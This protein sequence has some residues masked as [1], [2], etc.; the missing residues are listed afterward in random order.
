MQSKLIR[1]VL[2]AVIAPIAFGGASAQN[3]STNHVVTQADL[4]Q[5]LAKLSNWGRWGNDDQRGTLNL[6]TKV[7][8]IQAAA[9][10]KDGVTVSLSRDLDSEKAIDNTDPFEDV[11]MRDGSSDGSVIDRMSIAFQGEAHTHIDSVAHKLVD[12]K[13]Y[14]GYEAKDYV[15]MQKGITKDS[16]IN[17]KTGI[18][19]RGI[20]M[21]IPMLKGVPYLDPTTP[22]YVEDLEAWEK[23]A[24]VKVAPGD[25]IFIRTGRWVRRAKLGAWD[26]RQEQAGLDASVIP[27][28]KA[29]GVAL[30]GSESALSVRPTPATTQIKDP[31]RVH[32]VHDFALYGFGM[33][34]ID[35]CDLTALSEAAAA[36]KRWS[37]LVTAAPLAMP[38]GGGSPINPIAIF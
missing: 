32:V 18:F 9:L 27:W 4:D 17:M 15:S 2:V 8:I 30:I 1:F 19:T 23:R 25:A 13:M 16:I 35:A 28:L 38:K 26:T 36:R 24:G 33:P 20:L 29:R 7:K 3:S 5:W 22:I 10:V 34:V 31:K 37:F 21:D 12:G 14:N 6:I 11:M